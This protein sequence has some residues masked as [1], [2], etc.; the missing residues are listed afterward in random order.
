MNKA[1]LQKE[2]KEKV[3]PGKPSD[4]KK[5]K[6]KS[7]QNPISPSPISIDRELQEKIKKL[8]R[9]LASK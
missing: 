3:K 1:N 2:L 6:Q 4:L 8:E 7:T 5:E 9:K